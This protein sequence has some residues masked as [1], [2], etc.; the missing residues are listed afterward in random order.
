MVPQVSISTQ[1]P[2]FGLFLNGLFDISSAGISR[3]STAS[4]QLAVQELEDDND[5]D[6]LGGPGAGANSRV[7]MLEHQ[8]ELQLKKRNSAVQ[9]GMYVSSLFHFTLYAVL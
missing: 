4:S 5:G 9:S 6:I 2:D 3:P 7:R 1:C 8:R